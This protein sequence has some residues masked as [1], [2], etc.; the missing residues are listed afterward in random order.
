[1]VRD[2]EL[3][4]ILWMSLAV[5]RSE[6]RGLVPG[7][8]LIFVRA[9]CILVGVP[10]GARMATVERNVLVWPSGVMKCFLPWGTTTL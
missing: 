6:R 5:G 4:V 7:V 10:L 3:Q 9:L 2:S 8:V 1:V